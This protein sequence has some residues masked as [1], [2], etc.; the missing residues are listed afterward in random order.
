[1][2][3]FKTTIQSCLKDVRA[4][5]A[6]LRLELNNWNDD[7]STVVK[8]EVERNNRTFQLVCDAAI[9]VEADIKKMEESV[10]KVENISRKISNNGI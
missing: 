3:Q 10:D 9:K 2:S 1:M 7:K 6:S 5:L 8:A 4:V